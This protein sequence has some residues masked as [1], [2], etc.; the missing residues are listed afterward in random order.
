M[1]KKNIS[2]NL[3]YSENFSNLC[4]NDKY[5]DTVSDFYYNI[6]GNYTNYDELKD[7]VKMLESIDK[8]GNEI[9]KLDNLIVEKFGNELKPIN[10]NLYRTK[11]SDKLIEH[12]GVDQIRRA[13]NRAKDGIVRGYHNAKNSLVNAGNSFYNRTVNDAKGQVNNIKNSANIL[14]SQA[15]SWAT[16]KINEGLRLYDKYLS[17]SIN[18]MINK[19]KDVGNQ[20]RNGATNAYNEANNTINTVKS[21]AVNTFNALL[22]S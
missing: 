22:A 7:D 12:W 17:D 10:T 21:G 9:Q 18:D 20:I 11:N 6:F 1:I 16:S 4:K 3:K 14:Y 8:L 2:N 19:V 13:A 15:S 5:S